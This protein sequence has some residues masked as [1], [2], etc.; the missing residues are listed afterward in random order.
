MPDDEVIG[1]R[2]RPLNKSPFDDSDDEDEPND[3][4]E[5]SETNDGL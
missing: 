2:F 5:P 4:D 1:A 3:E